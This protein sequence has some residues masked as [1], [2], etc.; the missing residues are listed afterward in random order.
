MSN[1]GLASRYLRLEFKQQPQG[2]FFHQRSF[3]TSF[4]F[5]YGISNYNPLNIPFTKALKLQANMN[6]LKVDPT[7]YNQSLIGKLIFFTNT[8]LDIAFAINLANRYM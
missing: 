7:Y 5:E 1:L 2:T 8:R 6:S 4:F 3:S